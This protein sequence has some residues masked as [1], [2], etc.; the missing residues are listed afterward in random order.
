MAMLI[1]KFNPLTLIRP[2]LVGPFF[3]GRIAILCLAAEWLSNFPSPSGT[4]PKISS[5][6]DFVDE[7][8]MFDLLDK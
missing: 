3:L 6:D 4:D 2:S 8:E 1:Y 5:I 7:N